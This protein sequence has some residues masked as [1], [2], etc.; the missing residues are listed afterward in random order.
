MKDRKKK[1]TRERKKS[2]RDVK[3]RK[4]GREAEEKMGKEILYQFPF[5]AKQKK[6]CHCYFL[7]HFIVRAQTFEKSRKLL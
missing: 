5:T 2:K 4:R 3:K 6:T 7:N 1:I